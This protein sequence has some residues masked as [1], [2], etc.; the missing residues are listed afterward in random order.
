MKQFSGI[1]PEEIEKLM[2]QYYDSLSEKY[3]RTR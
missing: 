3:R 1:Y 2:K